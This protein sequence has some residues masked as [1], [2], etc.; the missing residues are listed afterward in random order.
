MDQDFGTDS[1]K[2]SALMSVV[3]AQK[4]KAVNALDKINTTATAWATGP[5]QGEQ[6]ALAIQELTK[7]YTEAIKIK[8]VLEAFYNALE[9]TR[10][11]TVTLQT[12][13]SNSTNTLSTVK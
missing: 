9:T 7:I 13:I 8:E 10:K 1:N 11:D 12:N 6:S 2:I 3:N 5:W 4:E